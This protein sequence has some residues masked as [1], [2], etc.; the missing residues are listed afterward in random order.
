MT[1]REPRWEIVRT[2]SGHHA[3]FRAS[4]GHIIAAT[5][6]YTRRS[7]A[8]RAIELITGHRLYRSPHSRTGVEVR[9][10]RHEYVDV[11]DVDERGES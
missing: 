4:N 1:P 5:E 3:R 9:H 8:E 7:R 10:G 6:V 11:V 2:D